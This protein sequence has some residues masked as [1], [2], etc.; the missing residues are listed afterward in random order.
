MEPQPRV[1]RTFDPPGRIEGK[2]ED[3]ASRLTVPSHGGGTVYQVHAQH[4]E[5][6]EPMSISPSQG[7]Q[8]KRAR[9][10]TGPPDPLSR[11]SEPVLQRALA[12]QRDGVDEI[13]RQALRE[14]ERIFEEMRKKSVQQLHAMPMGVLS[15]DSRAS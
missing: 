10:L 13:L 14:K 9:V 1:H 11:A 12:G 5:D 2:N 15:G 4:G 7:R 3:D 6:T 8:E